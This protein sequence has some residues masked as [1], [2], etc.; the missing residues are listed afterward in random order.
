MPGYKTN[1]RVW[2][3]ELSAVFLYLSI[4]IISILFISILT[5]SLPLP[6]LSNDV[7]ISFNLFYN[8]TSVI[9][10]Y[11]PAFLIGSLFY[12]LAQK[13]LLNVKKSKIAH[14]FIAVLFIIIPFYIW[15]LISFSLGLYRVTGFGS[16]MPAALIP[17]YSTIF[18]KP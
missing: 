4:N 14:V 11:L 18:I 6:F 15:G 3:G 5:V 17:F 13:Y 7:N 1:T 8:F 9:F 10:W 16:G 12:K 2:L